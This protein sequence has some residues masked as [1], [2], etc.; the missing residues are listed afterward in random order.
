MLGYELERR[1][2][3]LKFTLE[4][5]QIQLGGCGVA[6]HLRNADYGQDSGPLGESRSA[7]LTRAWLHVGAVIAG[8]TGGL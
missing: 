1:G 8:A 6:F 4:K 2:K 3:V 7:G 5:F